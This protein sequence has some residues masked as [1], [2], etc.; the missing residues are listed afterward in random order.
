MSN[1]TSRRKEFVQLGAG[2]GNLQKSLNTNF[3]PFLVK[4]RAPNGVQNIH[5]MSAKV[6]DWKG[7]FLYE[8]D[9]V[10][11][12]MEKCGMPDC[13]WIFQNRLHQVC[14]W[15]A[16][17][18]LASTLS[19]NLRWLLVVTPKILNDVTS[20]SCLL[21]M[22]RSWRFAAKNWSTSPCIFCCSTSYDFDFWFK[23][24]RLEIIAILCSKFHNLYRYSGKNRKRKRNSTPVIPSASF[25]L[26]FTWGFGGWF[27]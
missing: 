23:Y 1:L 13:T 17:F 3:L 21:A 9:L 15:D 16:F 14:R 11:K 7:T 24:I 2:L 19:F 6:Q 20:S 4:A 10:R 26:L 18:T 5:I 12:V 22:G 27:V 8:F 25:C